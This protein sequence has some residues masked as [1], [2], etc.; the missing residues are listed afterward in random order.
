MD[1]IIIDGLKLMVTGMGMVFVF[2]SIMVIMI[3]V[4]AK[5]L[6]PFAHLLEETSAGTSPRVSS[7]DDQDIIAAIVAAVHKYRNKS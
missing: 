3:M 2:L 1:N 4:L 5:I 7:E 6:K